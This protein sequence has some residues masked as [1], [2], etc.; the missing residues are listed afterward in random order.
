MISRPFHLCK[1]L[2]I[3]QALDI[4]FILNIPQHSIYIST[5]I[6][7][8]KSQIKNHQSTTPYW[9]LPRPGQYYFCVVS[10]V[11]VSSRSEREPLTVAFRAWRVWRR[12]KPM[13]VR[14]AMLSSGG[15]LSR[16]VAAKPELATEGPGSMKVG[17]ARGSAKSGK[18]ERRRKLYYKH[19]T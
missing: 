16:G 7:I 8:W 9:M 17:S 2:A 15:W 18:E 3:E 14:M 5:I 11:S 6:Q 1:V 10:P 19:G 4:W 12:G 13:E